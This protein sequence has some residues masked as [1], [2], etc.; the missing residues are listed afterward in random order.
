LSVSIIRSTKPRELRN[1]TYWMT[2]KEIRS[3]LGLCWLFWT[4]EFPMKLIVGLGY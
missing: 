3:L 1:T 4:P 2:L